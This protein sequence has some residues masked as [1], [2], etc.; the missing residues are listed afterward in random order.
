MEQY[1]NQEI[2]DDTIHPPFQDFTNFSVLV[3]EC[4]Y[5]Y[6]A[7][8]N[9][10]TTIVKMQPLDHKSIS[11]YTFIIGFASSHPTTFSPVLTPCNH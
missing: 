4:G 5:V 9:V 8:C 2:D 1:H 10:I 3:C 11:Y 7:L 6:S